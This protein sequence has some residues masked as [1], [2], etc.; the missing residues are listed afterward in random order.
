MRHLLAAKKM[1]SVEALIFAAWFSFSNA[2]ANAA[3][4]PE[5][6][7]QPDSQTVVLGGAALFDV[8]ATGGPLSYQWRK[9]TANISGATSASYI[10]PSVGTNDAG[11]YTVK[12]SNTA[13]AIT[14]RVATLTVILPPAVTLHPVPVINTNVGANVTFRV[15]ATGTAPIN[16]EWRKNDSPIVGA[17][18]NAYT[19]SNVQVSDS[20]IYYVFINNAAGG[21]RSS[22]A[23]LNVGI[24]PAIT[25]QPKANSVAVG[26][27]AVFT[28]GASGI[29]LSFYWRR[30]GVPIPGATN[31]P[32][33]LSNVTPAN[34]GTYSVIVSNF[35]RNVTSTGAGLT[36]NQPVAITMQPQSRT[37]GEGSNVVFSATVTGT[38]PL[39]YQWQKNG[40]NISGTGSKSPSYGIKNVQLDD[41]GEYAVVVTNSWSSSISQIA[42][43]TVLRYPP[44]IV[45]Q[46]Q[47]Q[48]VGV[49]SNLT[50]SVSAAGTTLAYQWRK[51]TVDLPNATASSLTIQNAQFSDAGSYDVRITNPIGEIS[52]EPAQLIVRSFPPRILVQP[53]DLV[54][55]VGQLVLLSVGAEGTSPLHFQWQ[56]EESEVMG[57]NDS[58]LTIPAAVAN[59]SGVYRVII[60]NALGSVTSSV[61][62]VT[63]G[64]PPL[65]TQQ[66]LSQ[67]GA[68]SAI[69]TFTAAL[70]GSDPIAVQWQKGGVLLPGE[71]NLT[72]VLTNAQLSQIGR[73][74]LF[75]SNLFGLTS[76]DM[77]IFHVPGYDFQDGL[78][79]FYPFDNNLNDQSGSGLNMESRDIE[80]DQDRFGLPGAVRLNGGTSSIIQQNRVLN[81]GE[82]YT[83]SLWASFD[84]VALEYQGL[85]NSIPHPGLYMVYNHPPS[86]RRL[87]FQLGGGGGWIIDDAGG[88]K[89]DYLAG[90]WYFFAFVKHG[91]SYRFLVNNQVDSSYDLS[92]APF[93]TGWHVGGD[94]DDFS[95][96]GQTLKGRIDDLRVYNRAFS[97]NEVQEL[98]AYE[99]DMPLISQQPIERIV[100][101]GASTTF[102][103]AATARHPLT[104]QWSRNGVPIPEATKAMIEIQ[105]AQPTAAGT[106]AVLIG[107][108]FTS[109]RSAEAKLVIVSS[110][111]NMSSDF[112][113]KAGQ[114]GFNISGSAGEII[115]IDATTNL[116]NWIPLQTNTLSQTFYFQDPA[117]SAFAFRYYRLRN[118]RD[119]V[120]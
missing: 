54:A 73:Y 85:F 46:P 17:S 28:V 74:S 52:S 89:K 11:N 76:S 6:T 97:S 24:A 12:I 8:V 59:D 63:I 48:T 115:I 87:R 66:P 16:Y 15:L 111:I 21:A 47:S 103:V 106:F 100:L 113:F 83:V 119:A 32:L 56:K 5:I 45:V 67:T 44:Q 25:S 18:L 30:N 91:S 19:L 116:L 36:V 88:L 93:I 62:R 64:Y 23:V 120:Q 101:A 98:Y 68:L 79:A 2:G 40:T 37:I 77:A 58:I 27:T 109:T 108:G 118:A 22:N 86:T 1:V 114:F 3:T 110:A 82:D 72:L 38:G 61:A 20:G 96:S 42:T 29:P 41:A 99:A 70:S 35:L 49:G 7:K 4:L 104:Y 31:S 112:G 84:N 80:F 81:L 14:S 10:M 75:A 57:P 92:I 78:L 60:T 50:F 26:Q 90:E 34:A 43:L 13:G 55:P 39:S 51:E 95:R 53:Q 33:V 65:F 117:S 9:D 107:N 105:D 102:S 71:T 94:G 69:I